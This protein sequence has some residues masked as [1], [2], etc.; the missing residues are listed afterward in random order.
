MFFGHKMKLSIIYIFKLKGIQRKTLRCSCKLFISLQVAISPGPNETLNGDADITKQGILV[1]TRLLQHAVAEDE[2]SD[3][4]RTEKLDGDW[5]VEVYTFN[6]TNMD[7]EAAVRVA[8][9]GAVAGL[10]LLLIVC[11]VCF[12]WRNRDMLVNENHVWQVQV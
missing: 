2:N 1:I 3:S 12:Y 10:I 4:N 8:A 11:A 9:T 7:V 6:A 5:N